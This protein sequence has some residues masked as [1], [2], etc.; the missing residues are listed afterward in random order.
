[1]DKRE[2]DEVTQPASYLDHVAERG[3]VSDHDHEGPAETVREADHNGHHIVIR[4]SYSIE[5]DGRA[6]TGHLAVG[7]DGRVTY[8]AVPNL[9]FESAVDLVKRLIDAFP[10]DFDAPGGG[11]GHGGHGDGGHGGHHQ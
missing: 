2:I 1:M 9:S 11:G 7:N 4:T 6:V 3:S 10:D 5:V 8:H